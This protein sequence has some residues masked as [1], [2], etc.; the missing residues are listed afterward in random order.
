[1]GKKDGYLGGNYRLQIFE[2]LIKSQEVP[3]RQD[4]QRGDIGVGTT[5]YSCRQNDGD[6]H[7]HQGDDRAL[8][9]ADRH[10][11][12][13]GSIEVELHEDQ[14]NQRE[15]QVDRE[16]SRDRFLRDRSSGTEQEFSG[17]PS[18]V[19]RLD[20]WLVEVAHHRELIHVS[21]EGGKNLGSPEG[22]LV[23]DQQVT[24]QP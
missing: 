5:A 9:P 13:A 16:E 22:A 4:R 15:S 17:V 7:E 2:N 23:P 21:W 8:E 18:Q 10:A 20:Q 1:R 24:G 6:N 11:R 12:E 3:V 19:Q 14:G